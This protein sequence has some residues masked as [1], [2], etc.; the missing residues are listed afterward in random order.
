[1]RFPTRLGS[2]PA[3][4]FRRRFSGT[5]SVDPYLTA[6]RHPRPRLSLLRRSA[7]LRASYC[8]DSR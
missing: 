3:L 7:T 1:V 2:I 4:S 8:H 5:G 6:A